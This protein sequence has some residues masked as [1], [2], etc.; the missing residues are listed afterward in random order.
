MKRFSIIAV[1]A[2]TIGLTAFLTQASALTLPD[3]TSTYDGIP[4]TSF[5]DDFWSYSAK[6]MTE[7]YD[8][9]PV[10]WPELDGYNFA[11]GTGGLDVILYTG[12]G[13]NNQEVGPDGP[14]AGH[15]G[16]YNFEDP[17]KDSGGSR[18]TFAG[19]WGQSDQ[20]N[21]GTPEAVHGPVTVDQMLAYLHAF[22]PLN[23]IPVFY[24]DLN[25]VGSESSLGFDGRIYLY[26]NATKTIAH[27]WALDNIYQP[28]DGNFDNTSIVGAPGAVSVTGISGTEY[29]VNHNLGSGKADF[30]AYAP[31]MDLGLYDGDWLFVTEF[32]MYGLNDGFEELF[33]TGNIQP[34]SRII[35]EPS[36]LVLLGTG[37]FG[38][39]GLIRRKKK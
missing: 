18:T 27:E 19:W 4:I 9:G 29:S 2:V 5:H 34:P 37:L 3:P 26:N 32:H 38:M 10:T 8:E 16:D 21:D 36:S 39:L 33:L 7:L 13:A 22:N 6:I 20:N 24:F 31:T 15:K 25:Q 1:I 23:N 12:S 30:I 17:V 28:G 14:D 35:P 11:T